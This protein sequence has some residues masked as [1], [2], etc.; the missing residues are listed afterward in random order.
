MGHALFISRDC[1]WS[2][3]V[4]N[5]YGRAVG[6]AQEDCVYF[7]N[8][9]TLYRS[10]DRKPEDDFRNCGVYNVRDQ[11][12]SPLPTEMASTLVSHAGPWSLTWFFLPQI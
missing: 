8:E 10:K 7:T 2:I 6:G 5:R 3:P 1:S 11:T 4:A 9:H 12:M